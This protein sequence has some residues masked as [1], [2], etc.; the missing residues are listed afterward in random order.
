MDEST[1]NRRRSKRLLV[2]VGA[3]LGA[4]G[5]VAAG[6]VVAGGADARPASSSRPDAALLRTPPA[7]SARTGFQVTKANGIRQVTRVALPAGVAVP[8]AVGASVVDGTSHTYYLADQTNGGVDA[9]STASDRFEAVLGQG[10]FV[11]AA[12]RE[13]QS[14][15]TRCGTTPGP[16]GVVPLQIGSSRQLVVGD[17][18]SATTPD[19][20]VT[21][22]SLAGP[23]EATVAATVPTGGTCGTGALAYDP[24]DHL[25][26]VAEGGEQPPVVRLVSMQ[27]DPAKDAVVATLAFPASIDGLGGL[28]FDPA[29]GRF[30]VGVPH[31]ASANGYWKGEVA[32]VDPKAAHVVATYVLGG[33]SPSG[34][35]LDP[36]DQLL[37]VGCSAAS[38]RGGTIGGV[39]YQQNGLATVVLDARTG[40]IRVHTYAVGGT[41]EVAYAPLAGAFYTASGAMTS[42][43]W[44]DGYPTPSLGVL[45]AATGAFV[46]AFPTAVGTMDVAADPASTKLVAPVRGYGIVVFV[47]SP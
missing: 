27:R 30:L 43:A 45:S 20:H 36:T 34:L 11:G 23:A 3:V 9:L 10:A 12:P 40:A 5:L 17:G 18:V 22:L 19:S 21:V 14:Q 8:A 13:S 33:C 26:A 1:V 44:K 39:Q 2:P 38:M 29:T 15:L 25:L 35:A 24:K 37:A 16:T 7:V 46:E 4:A 42:D 47:P 41:G 28:A 6:V 31:V 32:V